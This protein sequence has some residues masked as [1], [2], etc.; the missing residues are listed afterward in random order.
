MECA[1]VAGVYSGNCN[2]DF[3]KRRKEECACA[4]TYEDESI[5]KTGKDGGHTMLKGGF[6]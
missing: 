5:I 3:P 1:R 6:I 4:E 2:V